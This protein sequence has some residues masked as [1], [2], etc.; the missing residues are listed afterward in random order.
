MTLKLDIN[1]TKQFRCT[2][3]IACLDLYGYK[4]ENKTNQTQSNV[5]VTT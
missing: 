4:H 3:W 2:P 1:N 5:D